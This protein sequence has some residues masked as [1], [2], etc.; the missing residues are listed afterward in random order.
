[1]V[2]QVERQGGQ[3]MKKDKLK[4]IAVIAGTPV[5]TQMGM[6]LLVQNGYEQIS[7]YSVSEN[8][9]QQ[10]KFQTSNPDEQFQTMFELLRQIRSKGVSKVL[11]YCN[12][13]SGTVDFE[14]L[15]DQTGLSIV[16]PLQVYRDL[17]KDYDRLAV[18]SANAQGLAGIEHVCIQNNPSIILT[19]HSSINLVEAIEEGASPETIIEKYHLG[20]LMAYFSKLNVEAVLLGCTHFPYLLPQLEKTV[21]IPIINPAKKLIEKLGKYN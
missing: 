2:T 5:D 8:P 15:G 10:T 9:V 13:L 14:T 20:E 17:A 19:N 16:T 4:A 12:S 21:E 6:D 1:M 11:V 3:V 18:L 7:G